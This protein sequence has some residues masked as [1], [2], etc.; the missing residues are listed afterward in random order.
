[1]SARLQVRDLASGYGRVRVVRSVSFSLESGE[2]L[3]LLGPNG[4]GKTTTLMA[5]AGMLALHDGSIELDGESFSGGNPTAANRRGIVL[6]P[7]DR[8]L[9]PELTVKEHLVLACSGDRRPTDFLDVFPA[10]EKRWEL[11]AGSLSGGEQQMLAVARGLAQDPRVLLI[12]EMS[13]GLAPV[14]VQRLMPVVRRAA[15]ETG[16]AVVLVEQHVQLAL[17]VADQALVMAHGDVVL[18]GDAA[19]LAADPATIE[20]AYLG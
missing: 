10:L 16:A 20:S 4:A 17:E 7:D 2:I 19:E 3:A 1:M 11:A 6:V 5:L 14:I 12:D 13:M 15:R 9:F 18:R 8:A